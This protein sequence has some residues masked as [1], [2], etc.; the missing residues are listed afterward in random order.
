MRLQGKTA[1]VT[2]A[3]RGIGRAIALRYAAEG[4]AVVVHY[5]HSEDAA[6]EVVQQIEREG[7]RATAVWA[8]MADT[9]SGDTLMNAATA[10]LG[11]LDILVNNA[12]LE[13]HELVLGATLET[14]RKTMDVNLRGAFLL[15][16]LAA[17]HMQQRGGGKIIAIASVHDTSPLRERAVYSMSKAALTMMVKSMALE[18]GAFNIQ[19]NG[20]APGAILTDMN[21]ASL[22]DPVRRERLISR[23]PAGRL[24]N[25][26]DV[27]GAAVFL[28][29]TESDYVQGTTLYVDGGLLLT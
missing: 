25:P 1:I 29:S 22:E 11:K 19:V 13:I 20:I 4:A 7:G 3:E 10:Y 24:G 16:V 2:G 21:R 27:A 23:I 14:W 12:G 6:R 9:S 26:D 15:S 8:D 5:F 28:A 18:L 17:R